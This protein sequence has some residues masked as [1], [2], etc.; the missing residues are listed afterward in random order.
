LIDRVRA[1]V[2]QA[3]AADGRL[4]AAPLVRPIEEKQALLS[5]LVQLR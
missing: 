4:D 2:Y 1:H 3:F 5:C